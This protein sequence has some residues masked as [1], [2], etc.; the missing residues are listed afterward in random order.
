MIR[1]EIREGRL[2]IH[3]RPVATS[4]PAINA[5]ALDEIVIVLLDDEGAPDPRNIVAFD[6]AGELVWRVGEQA[7]G[8]GGTQSFVALWVGEGGQVLARN[9]NG[10]EY[11]VLPT[12]G[13]LE[14]N[15]LRRF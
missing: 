13:S 2:C 6:G 4:L 3:D 5:I 15:G 8:G 9:W 7:R 1:S 12:D 14:V 11:E 10:V